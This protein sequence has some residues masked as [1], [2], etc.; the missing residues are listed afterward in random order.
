MQKSL[1]LLP[2][3]VY[4]YCGDSLLWS[5]YKID[6]DPSK[7]C[8]QLFDPQNSGVP[9]CSVPC[10]AADN[11]GL[12]GFLWVPNPST[13]KGANK[14]V[15]IGGIQTD[16]NLA[17]GQS[18]CSKKAAPAATFRNTDMMQNNNDPNAVMLFCDEVFSPPSSYTLS[19]A[20][21]EY[22]T[23]PTDVGA[24]IAAHKASIAGVIIHELGHGHGCGTI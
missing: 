8:G 3:G 15:E 7:K 20:N 4:A 5:T 16:Q 2:N 9:P 23:T 19:N 11:N 17:S 24:R 22:W 1:G 6:P 10:T 12:G 21:L 18:F 14:W 13:V